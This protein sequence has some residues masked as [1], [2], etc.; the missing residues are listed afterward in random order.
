MAQQGRTERATAHQPVLPARPPEWVP[1]H[2]PAQVLALP[3]LPPTLPAHPPIR[4]PA[5]PAHL[6]ARVLPALL[7]EPIQRLER[8]T[9]RDP[10]VLQAHRS[11]PKIQ[12]LPVRA[13]PSKNQEI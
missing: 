13:A 7:Q 12:M 9:F 11:I 2:L 6:Q 8:Q 1:V 5:L 4:V 10:W 3:V